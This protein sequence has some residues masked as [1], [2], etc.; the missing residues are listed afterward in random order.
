MYD[1]IK[2][3][4]PPKS[5][6][7]REYERH[8]KKKLIYDKA[9]ELF[10]AYGYAETKI[11][12]ISKATGMSTGSIYHFYRNKEAI[13]LELS[14]HMSHVERLNDD[15]E[16][17]A[18]R[19]YEVLFK[20]LINYAAYWENLGVSLTKHVHSLFRRAYISEEYTY[21]NLIAYEQLTRFIALA[22]ELG[23]FDA[24]ISAKD[25]C[26]YLMTFGRGIIYEWILFDGT[27]SLTE[28]SRE[29]LPRLLRTFVI[30]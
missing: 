8:A 12:D 6:S 22:Q 9:I 21:K 2:G 11:A 26:A 4:L 23:T 10:A 19:P 27:F 3:Q 18:R 30:G 1:S 5:L 29:M 16:E 7:K 15:I 28:K 25:A 13:L 20:H 17:K 24:S 14:I